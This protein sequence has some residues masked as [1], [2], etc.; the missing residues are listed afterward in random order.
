MIVGPPRES[1]CR[2]KTPGLR[3]ISLAIAC[4]VHFLDVD[5]RGLVHEKHQIFFLRS[6]LPAARGVGQKITPLFARKNAAFGRTCK[7]ITPPFSRE[8]GAS[9]GRMPR[10]RPISRTED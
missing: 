9:A 5:P 6:R 3:L 2:L 8:P 7:K 1:H 4:V 10:G